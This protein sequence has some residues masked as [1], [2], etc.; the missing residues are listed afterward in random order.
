VE[1]DTFVGNLADLGPILVAE[2]KR[3]REEHDL[4]YLSFS[5]L[6]T[7]TAQQ[8]A[9]IKKLQEESRLFREGFEAEHHLRSIIEKTKDGLLAYCTNRPPAELVP[10]PSRYALLVTCSRCNS[11]TWITTDNFDPIDGWLRCKDAGWLCPGCQQANEPD[12]AIAIDVRELP[13][14]SAGG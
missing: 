4:A 1:E 5:R 13:D 6:R 7:K 3:L 11:G 9:Q 10:P 8:E 12:G 2:I 14:S